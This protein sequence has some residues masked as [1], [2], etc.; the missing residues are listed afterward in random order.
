M[1]YT[2]KLRPYVDSSSDSPLILASGKFYLYNKIPQP[3][4]TVEGRNSKRLEEFRIR[5]RRV[6]YYI[7]TIYSIGTRE[8]GTRRK[9]TRLERIN[10]DYLVIVP[11][12]TIT[13]NT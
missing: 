11:P 6:K 12:S 9:A 7:A 4:R 10:P 5:P 8:T 2:Y 3:T 13:A 1:P